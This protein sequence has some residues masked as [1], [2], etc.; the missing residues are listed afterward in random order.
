MTEVPDILEESR[1]FDDETPVPE[2]AERNGRAVETPP[3]RP[4]Q[5]G[6]DGED[7]FGPLSQSTL[8]RW[9]VRDHSL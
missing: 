2:R 8:N 7:R 1:S 4:V 3:Q 6:F 9:S 5:P